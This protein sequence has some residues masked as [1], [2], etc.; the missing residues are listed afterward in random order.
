MDLVT[1][2]AVLMMLTAA[3]PA[4]NGCRRRDALLTIERDR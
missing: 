2:I 3:V 1:F 4:A